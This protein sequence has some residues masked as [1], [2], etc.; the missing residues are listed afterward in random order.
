MHGVSSEFNT[1]G[2][3]LLVNYHANVDRDNTRPYTVGEA[4][5]LLG[6]NDTDGD[7]ART[8]RHYHHTQRH[9]HRLDEA[10]QVTSTSTSLCLHCR[11]IRKKKLLIRGVMSR[12]HLMYSA[13]LCT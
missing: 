5:Y 11:L 8:Q 2:N 3:A 13:V 7:G 1:T 12:S 9:Y 6:M 4:K 10:V